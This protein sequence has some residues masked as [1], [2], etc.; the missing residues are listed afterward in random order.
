[1]G[2][3]TSNNYDIVELHLKDGKINSIKNLYHL[4]YPNDFSPNFKEPD[5]AK[6][7]LVR[8]SNFYQYVGTTFQSIT[9]RLKQGLSANGKKGYHGY[10]WKNK[11]KV[12]V[13]VWTFEGINKSEIEN[14]EAELIFK[15][16]QKYGIWTIS[17]NEIHFNN[18][19]IFG[20]IIANDIFNFLESTHSKYSS[21]LIDKRSDSIFKNP[22]QYGLR[23]D[24]FLWKELKVT[25]ELSNV[26]TE[27]EFEEFLYS[28]FEKVTGEKL[29]P[30]Q[31]YDVSR[32]QF[33]GM[34]SGS[35]HGNFWIEKGFPLL[36]EQFRK[37]T[38]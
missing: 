19:F 5:I 25:Y 1:M 35:V 16:R 22:I 30:D 14:I 12:E 26:K 8:D 18:N 13:F 31:T 34:S 3:T 11:S 9:K 33:G 6:L 15:I 38:K 36:I 27:K 37:A 2:W 10:K 28:T 17:Q 29:I 23:G 7:Y 32:Y 24:P 4:K 21:I 20:R